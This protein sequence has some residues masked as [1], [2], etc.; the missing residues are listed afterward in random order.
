MDLTCKYDT[1]TMSNPS[2][3]AN[4]TQNKVS[5]NQNKLMSFLDTFPTKTLKKGS[6]ILNPQTVE[7]QVKYK[8]GFF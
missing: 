1:F 4:N 2:I 5:P 6:V 8:S 7:N 3:H